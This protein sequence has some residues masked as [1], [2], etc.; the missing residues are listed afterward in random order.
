MKVQSIVAKKKDAG[1][2]QHEL[3]AGHH[4]LRAI[5][6]SAGKPRL[7]DARKVRASGEVACERVRELI[8]DLTIIDGM[9][10]DEDETF[11][12]GWI[13]HAGRALGLKYP[14]VWGIA[15]GEITSISTHTVD[16]ISRISGVPVRIFYDA[17][18]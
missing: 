7:R 12:Y 5:R 3:A 11:R 6:E 18:I 9:V 14:T 10:L 2:P 17:D 8:Y 13:A 16:R 4:I 1:L 15:R